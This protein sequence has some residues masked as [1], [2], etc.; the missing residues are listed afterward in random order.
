M[1]SDVS[2]HL[3]KL[4]FP[5]LPMLDAARHPGVQVESLLKAPAAGFKPT[6]YRMNV[7]NALLLSF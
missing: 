1:V 6:S 4:V 2:L 5:V 3:Y 7:R